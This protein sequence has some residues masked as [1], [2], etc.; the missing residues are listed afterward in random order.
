MGRFIC[1]GERIVYKLLFQLKLLA[2]SDVRETHVPP[3]DV[4]P[5]LPSNQNE[6]LT[7]ATIAQAHK[8]GNRYNAIARPVGALAWRDL[9]GFSRP[10]CL[11]PR[12][13]T[14]H[15]SN[16]SGKRRHDS[17]YPPSRATV[18]S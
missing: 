3:I 5:G 2:R 6:T 10:V 14:E 16:P 7:V 17:P 15:L 12:Q 18:F 4:G 8:A 11:A 1:S 9:Q 13:I